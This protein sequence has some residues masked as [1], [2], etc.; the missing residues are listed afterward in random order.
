VIALVAIVLNDGIIIDLF[1]T[2]AVAVVRLICRLLA[3]PQ[4]FQN[5]SMAGIASNVILI[6]LAQNNIGPGDGNISS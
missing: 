2:V 4:L 1:E 5:F 6:R 3:V